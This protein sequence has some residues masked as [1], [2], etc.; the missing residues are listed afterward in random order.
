M[1][2]RSIKALILLGIVLAGLLGALVF[3]SGKIP[4]NNTARTVAEQAG[5]VQEQST[6]A[7]LFSAEHFFYSETVS[8]TL[9]ASESGIAEIYYT[10]DSTDPAT[11]KTAICYTEPIDLTAGEENI[12]SYTIKACGKTAAGN[13]DTIT[14]S[15]FVGEGIT[16]RFN[17]YVFSVS[18]DPKNLYDYETGIFVPGKLRDDYMRESGDND[19]DPPAPANYNLRGK[20]S[21]REAYVEAFDSSGNLLLSQNTGIRVAGGWSRDMAQK[22]I[23]L[24]ARAEYDADNPKFAYDFFNGESLRADETVMAES[25]RLV[26]RNN[27]NDNPFAFLRDEAITEC[28]RQTPLEDTQQAVPCAVFLNGEYYGFAWLHQ[29]FDDNYFDDKYGTESGDWAILSGGEGYKETDETDPLNAQAIADYDALYAYADKDLTDNAVFAELETRM[30]VE[31]FLYYY[32]IQTYIANEDWPGGNY[33]VYRYYG[34]AVDGSESTDGKW[35]WLLFDTDFG[36][37]LYGKSVDTDSLGRI[38][39]PGDNRAALLDAM[40]KREDIRL[41]FARIFCD[42]SNRAFSYENVEKT[43]REK[44]SARQNELEYNFLYGIQLQ[45]T[46]SSLSYVAGDV[47]RILNFA[48]ERPAQIRQQVQTYLGVGADGYTVQCAAT[49]NALISVNSCEI[50][51]DSTDFSGFYFNELKTQMTAQIADGYRFSHWLV[52]D[53]KITTPTLTLTAQDG[54]EGIVQVSLVLEPDNTAQPVISQISY[55]GTGDSFVI[56]NPGT[57]SI[58]LGDCYISD[59]PDTPKKQKLPNVMLAAG[60]SY[61]VYCDNYAQTDA[62]G[63]FS[64]S[65]SLKKGETLVLS[66]KAGQA[67]CTVFLPDITKGNHYQ[68]NSLTQTYAEESA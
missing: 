62:L 5:T 28:A 65:F 55:A 11:S 18:T 48:A 64:A 42:L 24:F 10:T 16:E 2:V 46:W 51:P 60:E 7:I 45:G 32:A 21:E 31:N 30:D 63:K 38:L 33:K 44:E 12:C 52:N 50:L 9:T 25:D 13:T 4:Y 17:T 20:E 67:L 47:E 68:R 8:L 61:T 59:S 66:N 40:L 1:K 34:E 43:V 56:T 14:H 23:K 41:E 39:N 27:A 3:A 49:A 19:P 6:G 53:A 29:V 57:K 37:G 36:M 54:I 58:Y 26:L 22:S 35:R 15:Y